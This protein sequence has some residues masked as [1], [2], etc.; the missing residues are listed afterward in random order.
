MLELKLRMIMMMWEM[1]PEMM[2][3][4][5]LI[6]AN[7]MMMKF[8]EILDSLSVEEINEPARQWHCPAC[9]DGPGAIDWYRGLQPLTTHAKTV[10]AKRVKLHRELAELLEEELR[11]RGTS[12]VPSG[13]VFG[14]WNG[15]KEE[16]KDHD[17]IWPPMVLIMN[18]WLE[19]DDNEK[20]VGMGNQELL[21]CFHNYAAVKARHS[22]GPQGHRGM[23]VLIF[24]SN[25]KG[26]LEA[27][28]LHKHFIEQ[29]TDRYAWEHRHVLFHPGGKRQ[30]YGFL[31][32]EED[33]EIFNKHS[34][35]K[36]KLKYE[37]RSFHEMVVTEIRRMTE[38]NQQLVYL[39][40]KVVKE[41]RH[42]K[43][44]EESFGFV[45]EKLRKTMKENQIV[46]QRTQMQHEQNK[47]ALDFQ[48]QFFKDQMDLMHE[49]IK[50]KEEEFERPQQDKRE[51][52]KQSGADSST[53]HDKK[54]RL[55]DIAKLIQLQDEEMKEFVAEREKL[56]R[57]HEEKLQ[58]MKKRHWEEELELE[59]EFNARLTQLMG[60]CSQEQV[61]QPVN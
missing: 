22:Y 38:D 52:M 50:A 57:V 2:R 23:S 35:G 27:E 5:I 4:M 14:K 58:E 28:R 26:Y 30:L 40:D 43:K 25:P 32:G 41:Q 45:S 3:K 36:T 55:E 21:D 39:K 46:R 6:L 17:I 42:A 59:K 31:P 13:E 19:K 7:S 16:E 15:L 18:T 48:E 61:D 33:L 37:I 12:V 60:K 11:R 8:F 51:K 53:A 1:L 24:E 49:E 34:P 29:G 56:V 47:E 20:W 9:Q 44:L 10:G 54:T